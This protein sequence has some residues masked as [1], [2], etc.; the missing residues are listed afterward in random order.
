MTA[1]MDGEHI[2]VSSWF[3]GAVQ[4]WDPSTVPVLEHHPMPVPL[5]AIRFRDDLVVADLGLGGVVW[6]SD[7]TVVLPIDGE[8]VFVPAGL[9]TDGE[10]LWVGD[11][12]TGLVWQVGF[13]GRVPLAPVPVVSGL[14]NPEGL[15]VDAGGG[16]LVVEAAAGRLSH[17]DLAT[18]VVSVVA[19]GLTT[20][21]LAPEGL[22]PTYA[23]NGV[24]VGPSGAIYMTG[25][26]VLYRFDRRYETSQRSLYETWGGSLCAGK[27][28]WH[29]RTPRT[30]SERLPVY[31]RLNALV[32]ASCGAGQ[33]RSVGRAGASLRLRLLRSRPMLCSG[34]PFR[35]R[36]NTRRWH[37][38]GG[39]RH[40]PRYSRAAHT[41]RMR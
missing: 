12:A 41:W 24:A 8:S 26:G 13:D 27:R 3:G 37:D 36:E 25:T 6:A 18:G 9:A 5:N 32:G 40:V 31:A 1:S 17:I 14:A 2:V 39:R 10:T 19:D 4:V 30:L 7:H 33:T 16:L 23:L 22:P 28:L 38:T 21:F 34:D 20:G 29:R 15:A 11:W 35:R